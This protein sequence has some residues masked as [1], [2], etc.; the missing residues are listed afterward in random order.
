MNKFNTPILFIIFNRPET[1]NVVF[2]AIRQ[3]KPS[4]L[5]I[6][7]DGPRKNKP[8]EKELCEE[9]RKITEK[10][11]WECEVK[12][13]FREENLGCGKAPSQAI[14]W[15]LKNVEAGIILEDDC[16]PNPSFFKYC[17]D[18]LERYRLNNNIY[19][20]SGNNFLPTSL[21]LEESYY[22]SRMTHIWG[23]AT[24]RRAWEKYD[25]QMS[26]FS[27]FVKNR[28]IEKIWSDKKAQKYWLEKFNEISKDHADIWDYQWTYMIWKNN[29][30]S[31][32]PNVNLISNIGFGNKG[33]HTLNK[34]DP[35]ANLPVEDMI[36]PLKEPSLIEYFVG[37]DYENKQLYPKNSVIKKIL[38][39]LGLFK[40]VKKFYLLLNKR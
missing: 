32:A 9:T 7:A 34:N 30:F 16:L 18:L 4:K 13:L 40:T 21:R 19:M 36:F 22:L 5:F 33:T 8:G 28:T 15:F 6:A 39:K 1:T 38:K 24:W 14:T 12:T 20:I 25:F 11:D 31:I 37:D 29:G 3:A 10:I 17:E 27:D 26:D 35:F 23:W 2:E